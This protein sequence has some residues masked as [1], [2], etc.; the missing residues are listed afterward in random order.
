MLKNGFDFI[1]SYFIEIDHDGQINTSFNDNLNE[2]IIFKAKKPAAN[3]HPFDFCMLCRKNSRAPA[4]YCLCLSVIRECV[5]SKISDIN[6]N[7]KS[8]PQNQ[9][10]QIMNKNDRHRIFVCSSIVILRSWIIM[11]TFSQLT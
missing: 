9:F 10:V 7:D 1:N 2:M 11:M 4:F 5:H 8:L 3:S 6:I